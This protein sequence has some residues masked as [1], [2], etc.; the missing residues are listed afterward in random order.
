MSIENEDQDKISTTS[1]EKIPK[2]TEILIKEAEL[3]LKQ[4]QDNVKVEISKINNLVKKK[5][6]L[7]ESKDNNIKK[8]LDIKESALQLNIT[9]EQQTLQI[10]DLIESQE[11]EIKRLNDEKILL[12]R[13]KIHLDI[14][15]N[16]KL[17]VDD[18]KNNN[19]QLQSN[20]ED[21][22]KKIDKLTF[23]NRKLLVNNNELKNTISR[24]IK[25][26]KNLQS[27]I[28]QLKQIQSESLLDKSRI[29]DMINQIKF[30]QDDN[31]RLSNE[32]IQIKNK[33]ETIRNNFNESENAKN[34]IFKQIQDLNNSLIK[35]NIVGTPFIK[36]KVPE[37]SINS[38]IINNISKTNLEIDEK[39]TNFN[40]DLDK[41]IEDIFS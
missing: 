10:K 11:V 34:D 22:D 8:I 17:L 33:Y 38:K 23:E 14:I 35:T 30:Y 7:I 18:Y 5:Y 29:N 6:F 36:D 27:S 25:H 21:L 4:N 2:D 39:K 28:A 37:Q 9:A 15:E 24:Y 1:E 26:N 41:K 40:N 16:Q 12:D 31:S 3:S 20:L 19:K 32:L 13:N